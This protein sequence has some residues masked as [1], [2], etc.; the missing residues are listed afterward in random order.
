[1]KH[2]FKNGMALPWILCIPVVMVVVNDAWIFSPIGSLDPWI[3]LSLGLDYNS[4]LYDKYYKSARIVWHMFQFVPRAVF[5]PVVAQYIIKLSVDVA[6]IALCYALG[7]RLFN[8]L[9]AGLLSVLLAVFPARYLGGADSYF[10]FAEPWVLLVF[11]L[12]VHSAQH[13][14]IKRWGRYTGMAFGCLVHTN[15]VTI[16]LLPGYLLFFWVLSHATPEGKKHRLKTLFGQAL[17]GGLLITGALMLVSKLVFGRRWVFFH[18][19]LKSA[20]GLSKNDPWHQPWSSGWYLND[21]YFALLT[22]GLALAIGAIGWMFWRHRKKKSIAFT[23]PQALC[24][25]G[26]GAYCLGYLFYFIQQTRGNTAFQPSYTAS[27]LYPFLFVSIGAHLFLLQQNIKPHLGYIVGAIGLMLSALYAFHPITKALF[28]LQ[29]MPRFYQIVAFVLLLS[30]ATWVLRKV[31]KPLT[32]WVWLGWTAILLPVFHLPALS[33]VFHPSALSTVLP[34]ISTVLPT[35]C[36]LRKDYYQTTSELREKQLLGRAPSKS[37]WYKHP[38][39]VWTDGSKASITTRPDCPKIWLL[40]AVQSYYYIVA[41]EVLRDPFSLEEFPAPQDITAKHMQKVLQQK[42]PLLLLFTKNAEHVKA[43]RQRFAKEGVTLKM[44][45]EP[46]EG[47]YFT[48]P[49]YTA[50]LLR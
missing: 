45:F 23:R 25:A 14:D 6:S 21:P 49:M 46:V 28:S 35:T 32:L 4:L 39:F 37:I 11:L 1:M 29:F 24:L 44:R 3:D 5:S 30:A 33:T 8:P 16:F 40:H 50:T 18:R 43:F 48:M 34:T 20:L 38:V 47:R 10:H 31:N 7:L 19:M 12:L 13:A 17:L 15:L 22:S 27:V 36:P 2:N 42:D 26:H 9:V 41:G